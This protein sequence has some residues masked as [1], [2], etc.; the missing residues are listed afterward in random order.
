MNGNDTVLKNVP[1]WRRGQVGALTDPIE[2]AKYNALVNPGHAPGQ[3]L[4]GL[5]EFG[6]QGKR[7]QALGS[8]AVLALPFVGPPLLKAGWKALSTPLSKSAQT[9]GPLGK[10]KLAA[11]RLLSAGG[12]I[13][14]VPE[15]RNAHAGT[16][17]AFGKNPSNSNIQRMYDSLEPKTPE[18]LAKTTANALVEN[19]HE[20]PYSIQGNLP[21]R[22][23]PLRELVADQGNEVLG[24]A[25]DVSGALTGIAHT[26]AARKLA[27]LPPLGGDTIPRH[28]AELLLGIGSRYVEKAAGPVS[29]IP[30]VGPAISAAVKKSGTAIGWGGGAL[31]SKLSGPSEE[32]KAAARKELLRK[33]P[34]LGKKQ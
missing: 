16:R 15:I 19:L 9:L 11:S 23:T 17:T 13:K 32:V 3:P 1:W 22:G 28:S 7:D 8:A 12:V 29:K 18:S 20:I 5:G 2:T 33:Y 21:L 24:N 31:Q 27:G 10:S 14:Q 30:V 6:G 34:W 4:I 25:T 26:A